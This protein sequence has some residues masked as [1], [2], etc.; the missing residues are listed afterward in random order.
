MPTSRGW[1]ELVEV[2]GHPGLS[3]SA[4]GEDW[5]WREDRI[6]DLLSTEDAPIL[7]LSGCASNMGK[8]HSRFDHIVLLSAPASLIVERLDR[9]TTNSYGKA[10]DE[11]ARVLGHVETVEPLLRRVADAEIDTSAPLNDVVAAILRIVQVPAE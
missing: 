9:R 1:S 4:P 5:V 7:F 10:P 3:D 8:F 2:T 11:L 6:H